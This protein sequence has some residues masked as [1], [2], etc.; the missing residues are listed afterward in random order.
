MTLKKCAKR[1][2]KKK[3]NFKGLLLLPTLV[4]KNEKGE[5]MIELKSTSEAEF[6][7]NKKII[8]HKTQAVQ[9]T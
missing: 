1:P 5:A 3:P 4:T 6:V 8:N 7:Y 2:Y 9:R